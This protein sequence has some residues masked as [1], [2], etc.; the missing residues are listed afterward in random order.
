MESAGFVL[1][2]FSNGVWTFLNIPNNKVNFSE[3]TNKKI[4]HSS[5]LCI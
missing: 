5:V 1:I 3:E 2:D 4:V